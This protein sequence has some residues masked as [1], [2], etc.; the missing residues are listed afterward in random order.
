[1]DINFT[2]DLISILKFIFGLVGLLVSFTGIAFIAFGN[3]GIGR[4]ATSFFEY[5][6]YSLFLI[7]GIVI[8]VWSW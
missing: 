1:M 6:N 4:K 2:I 8:M 5:I 3:I 7:L